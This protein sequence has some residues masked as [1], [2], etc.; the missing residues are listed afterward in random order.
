M[1]FPN[2]FPEEVRNQADIVRIISDYV[3]LKKRGSNWVACCPFHNEKTPSFSVHQGKQLFKCFGC[4]VAGDVFRFVRVIE[5][6]SYPESVRTV[7]DKCGIP[8]PQVEMT[9]DFKQASRERDD[10]LQLN[11]W[12]AQFFEEQ[13]GL[14]AEGKRA[15]EYVDSRGIQ[16]ETRRQFRLGYA[17]NSW[18]ALLTELKRRGA[19]NA[20]VEKSGLVTLR[21]NGIGYY[22]KFRG[23]VMFPIF[24]AQNRIIAFGGRIRDGRT[25]IFELSRDTGILKGSKP[26]WAQ[27]C[28]RGHSPQRLCNSC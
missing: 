22:D 9:E 16:P 25:E 20:Q 21:E 8:V 17:P 12:A 26:V 15:E 23:R 5:G 1:R 4:G 7:A 10:L 11:E 6:C 3:S 19:E 18:D 24:D 27:F 14:G 13:L 28:Q 2:N